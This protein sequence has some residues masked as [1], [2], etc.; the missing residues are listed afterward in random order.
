MSLPYQIIPGIMRLGEIIK[1]SEEADPI[2]SIEHLNQFSAFVPKDVIVGITVPIFYDEATQLEDIPEFK[3]EVKEKEGSFEGSDVYKAKDT[4]G[5]F[6][7]FRKSVRVVLP[8]APPA[9]E[10][11]EYEWKRTYECKFSVSLKLKKWKDSKADEVLFKEAKSL[12]TIKRAEGVPNPAVD[13]SMN[14]YLIFLG[15]EVREKFEIMLTQPEWEEIK[16][17]QMWE[18]WIKEH[19][20]K[21][22]HFETKYGARGEDI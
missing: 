2:A 13:E 10:W 18:E 19:E 20:S 12:V 22:A 17:E 11:P 7:S 5:K 3:L 1:A 14:P 4:F 15:Y 6:D 16:Y 8:P 21:W 9:S